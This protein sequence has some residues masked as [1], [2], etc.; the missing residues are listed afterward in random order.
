MDYGE[1]ARF[2]MECRERA[3]QQGARYP[4]EQQKRASSTIYEIFSEVSDDMN[5]LMPDD[6]K[7]MGQRDE[8]IE[9]GKFLV[10]NETDKIGADVTYEQLDNCFGKAIIKIEKR[11]S[12][13][14][15]RPKPV[16]KGRE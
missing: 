14:D 1:L 10:Q 11:K 8:M 5:S 7:N 4:K 12:R 15:A 16:S 2:V 6:E 3:S 9:K 13:E